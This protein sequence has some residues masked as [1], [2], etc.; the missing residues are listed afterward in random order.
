MLANILRN[1][2]IYS[3]A[4]LFS[5]GTLLLI[6]PV[7]TR[8]F[9]V[10]DYGLFEYISI[11]GTLA[12]VT[13]A[14]EIHQAVARFTADLHNNRLLMRTYASTAL[15]FTVLMHA[16]IILI[17]V[18]FGK[19][20]AFKLLGDSNL[21]VLLFAAALS[22][23]VAGVVNV[24]VTQLQWELRAKE[25]A[26]LSIISSLIAFAVS[27]LLVWA[28]RWGLIGAYLG[29]VLS[30]VLV[31]PFG[32]WLAS[33]SFGLVFS[34][35]ALKQ[36]LTFSIP[37][38][39]SSVGWV[40]SSYLDRLAIKQLLTY[41]DVAVFG[42]GFKIAG[43]VM[44]LMTGLQGAVSPVIYAHHED[45]ETPGRVA[46]MLRWFSAVALLFCGFLSIFSPELLWIFATPD[47]KGAVWVIPP[48]ALSIVLSRFYIFAPGMGLA[49]KTVL[50]AVVNIS[51][52]LLNLGLN[53]V[54]I[55]VWGITGAAAATLISA[56]ISF[57]VIMWISQRYYEVP[58][59][60]MPMIL[61]G[62]C[63]Y[64]VMM[65]STWVYDEFQ[66]WVFVRVLSLLLLL[67][68]PV[69][70]G[71]VSINELKTGVNQVKIRFNF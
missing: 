30:G 60:F 37:L 53:Y 57:G 51:T 20:I 4:G 58:H 25:S 6:V 28:L 18:L 47:Y 1:S 19:Y 32:L 50:Y 7:Y 65:L 22:F 33:G 31:V 62:L 61:M 66:A 54:L 52:G 45:T 40:L 63:G 46:Q 36:M 15:V 26:L 35:K 11:I 38:V 9:S 21:S 70:L 16:L 64:S 48:L 24:M 17:T 34:V 42:V 12:G 41:E 44:L 3:A 2:F 8:I 69:L 71:V 55:P 10:K 23:G 14:L 27:M 13:I 43:M 39:F 68:L 5:G 29:P 67:I 56:C 49:K 59:K